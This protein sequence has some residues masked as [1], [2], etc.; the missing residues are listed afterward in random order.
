MLPSRM[1]TISLS[2]PMQTKKTLASL[3]AVVMAFTFLLTACDQ[4]KPADDMKD[5][6]MNNEMMEDDKMMDD[7]AME[8]DSMMDG[9][10]EAEATVN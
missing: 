4:K 1:N 5:D 6:K 3:F 9:E 2:F 8:D 10:V 7:E